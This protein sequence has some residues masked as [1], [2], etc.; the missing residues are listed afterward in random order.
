MEGGEKTEEIKVHH[1]FPPV[2]RRSFE[3]HNPPLLALYH[4]PY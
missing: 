4:M 2:E 3:V 1:M